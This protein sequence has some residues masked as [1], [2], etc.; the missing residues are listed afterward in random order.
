[1]FQWAAEAE[2][3]DAEDSDRL[4]RDEPELAALYAASVRGVQATGRDAGRRSAGRGDR[5]D[6]EEI[7]PRFQPRCATVEGF[8]IHANVGVPAH[9][10]L[11]RERLFR[12]AAR[13]ALALE[14]LEQLSDGRLLYRFKTAWRD[15][16][17][18]IVFTP[19][20]LLARLA[21]LIPA[22]RTNLTRYSGVFAPTAKWRRSIVPGYGTEPPP[23]GASTA[24]TDDGLGGLVLAAPPS[25]PEPDAAAVSGAPATRPRRNYS[26]ADLMRRVFAR[27]VLSCEK[28]G[29]PMRILSAKHPP[30]TTRKILD[31]LGLPCRAPPIARAAAIDDGFPA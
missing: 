28:C 12:Y 27:D 1:V 24:D 26:W 17:D 15:G 21:A 8:S 20:E 18:R 5:V 30:E 2:G 29:G 25:L 22:P 4:F 6:P 31:C 16:T 7:E 9:D 13:P 19:D 11:R 23:Y 10:R 14:R 3:G